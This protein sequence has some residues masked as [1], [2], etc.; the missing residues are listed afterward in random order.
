MILSISHIYEKGL[1]GVVAEGLPS[2]FFNLLFLLFFASCGN[3]WITL[4][5]FVLKL[6]LLLNEILV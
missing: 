2:C 6:L 1:L 3:P 5:K 4:V